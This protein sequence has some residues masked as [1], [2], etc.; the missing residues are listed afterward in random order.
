MKSFLKPFPAFRLIVL[1]VLAAYLTCTLEP[2]TSA[3]RRSLSAAERSEVK[4][5]FWQP[6]E[7]RQ[8]SPVLISVELNGPAREVNGTWL[9][10][11][12]RF[13]R[14]DKPRLW[15]ALA[16]A[17]IDQ[18]PGSFELRVSATTGGRIVHLAKQIEVR[19]AQFGT[20]EVN[21]AQ[22]YVDPTR[23]EQRQIAR[24]GL[25]KNHAF[26][27]LTPRPLWYGNF[28]NPVEAESTPSFG[29]IRLMNEEKTSRH[30]GTDFPAKEGTPVFAS[31]AGVV[32][33]AAPLFYEGNCVIIDHGY[34]L[35]TVYMH[36]EK[37]KV[38]RGERV[39]KHAE[40][41][42]SGRTGRVT[43]PH[44][45][46]EM[47]WNQNHLDP[48]QLLALTLPDRELHEVRRGAH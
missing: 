48:V 44:L 23:E 30:L 47:M 6:D 1:L 7:V 26:A 25:L 35:F 36:L 41:G 13:L 9:G 22:D 34:R 16:G 29:E 28:V 27:R 38:H 43:G 15:V 14:S 40:I 37:M 31:N 45:H 20:S 12:I 2:Q 33:L 39:R 11:R 42:L 10:K 21:V 5:I 3:H 46:L 24:D 32:A 8:G 17:D 18:K 4:N 19:E